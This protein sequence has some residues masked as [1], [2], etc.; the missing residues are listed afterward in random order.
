MFLISFNKYL[1]STSFVLWTVALI[2][3]VVPVL[4]V[5]LTHFRS[6]STYRLCVAFLLELQGS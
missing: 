3:R 2:L 5:T 6:P 1:L 4:P